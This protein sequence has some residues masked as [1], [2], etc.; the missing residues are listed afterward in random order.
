MKFQLKFG[1][2]RIQKESCLS[3]IIT[4]HFF[5]IIASDIALVSHNCYMAKYV[6]QTVFLVWSV[7]LYLTFLHAGYKINHLLRTMPNSML[8]R[9]NSNAHQKGLYPFL[10]AHYLNRRHII[11]DIIF[12]SGIMQLAILAPYSNLASSVAAALM[13][14]ILGPKI[15]SAEENEPANENV[16]KYTPKECPENVEVSQGNEAF[17]MSILSK[18]FHNQVVFARSNRMYLIKI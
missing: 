6:L 15:R 4:A 18:T 12:Y 8:T 1:P 7:L 10:L 13:P 16:P 2:E 14:T 11:L 17:V 5:F 9:D 3:L